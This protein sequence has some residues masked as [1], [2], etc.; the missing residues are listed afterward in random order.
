MPYR[1]DGLTA[2]ELD[3]LKEKRKESQRRYYLANK[4]KCI[5][6]SMRSRAKAPEKHKAVQ[7]EYRR[8]EAKKIKEYNDC[9]AKNSSEKKAAS[10]AKWKAKNRAHFDE[11]Q[12]QYRKRNFDKACERARV[13]RMSNRELARA[14]AATWALNNKDKRCIGEQNRRA[15]AVGG[16]LSLGLPAKLLRM[17]K[18]KCT[19]CMA[20][21][22]S[23]YHLDHIMPLA[24]GG[25]NEDANIQ[26]LCP[27]C[28]LSKHAMHPVDFMQKRG[29]LL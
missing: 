23:G 9:Y 14:Y 29:F 25:K 21:I 8:R 27:S 11:Y 4:Q 22:D 3:R 10:T 2:E 19:C 18:G 6:A 16:K 5:D 7:A 15:R 24:L 20:E 13:W 26:L 28:N 1:T 12:K 17:Q